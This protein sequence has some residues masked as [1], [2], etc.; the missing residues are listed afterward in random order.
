MKKRQNHSSR[1][2]VVDIA[3]GVFRPQFYDLPSGAALRR[4]VSRPGSLD[5]LLAWVSTSKTD[6]A[7]R[8][9]E[10]LELI[11]ELVKLGH[12]KGDHQEQCLVW[13]G[14]IYKVKLNLPRPNRLPKPTERERM[15][16]SKLRQRMSLSIYKLKPWYWT[17]IGDYPI[18]GW[19]SAQ[20]RPRD[21]NDPTEEAS[22]TE[23]DAIIAIL[24]LAREGLLRNVRRCQHCRVWFLG[25]Q[26][27]KFCS[28]DCQQK[29]YRSSDEYKALRKDYM[30]NLRALHKK[31]YLVS[32][33]DRASRQ[34][35]VK[36]H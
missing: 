14:R 34:G 36:A 33:K 7:V 5:E 10:I 19:F 3:D 30:K 18:F 20:D 13:R 1:L 22:F 11:T 21:E 17:T 12:E 26:N 29:Y 15:L 2:I 28:L 9:N 23:Q 35:R 6:G 24:D 4:M 25:K 31:T 32:P 16:A 8:I 27:K